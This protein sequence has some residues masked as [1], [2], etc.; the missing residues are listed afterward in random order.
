[1]VTLGGILIEK[2]IGSAVVLIVF[3]LLK[4]VIDT[5]AAKDRVKNEPKHETFE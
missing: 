3:M 5:L 4:T 2:Y 1:M